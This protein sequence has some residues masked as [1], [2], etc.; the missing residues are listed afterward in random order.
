MSAFR[1]TLC[2]EVV[3]Q[4]PFGRQCALAAALGYDG[5]EIAP[6]TL[7]DDPA[8]LTAAERANVRR[9]AESEGIAITGL[10]WLLNVPAGLSLTGDDPETHR[11][12]GDHMAAMVDLCADL[13]GT[14][15]VHGSPK[16]RALSDAATPERARDNALA[17][18]RRAGERAQGA[19]VVY[20]IEPL[21]PAMTGFVTNVREALDIVDEIGIPALCTMIDTLAAWGGESEEPDALIRRHMPSGRIRHIHLNDD[22]S[23]A[24]GQ[25]ERRFA[26]ILQ[27][28]FDTEYDG[29]IG[30]EPFDYHPDG[31]TAA[32]RA[33]GY[34]RGIAETLEARP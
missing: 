18:L 13:G 1:F 27:A 33:I 19:G 12:T 10:H 16:Q 3:A 15:I 6:F 9:I 14:V 26:P 2:N 31:P 21:S 32:A 30:I 20:C 23:R 28:L 24:P 22:N 17:L 7:S 4:L 11:R 34:L 25:G 5:L 8:S 29:V